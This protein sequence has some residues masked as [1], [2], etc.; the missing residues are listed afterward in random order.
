[1]TD[2]RTT[3]ADLRDAVEDFNRRFP[4][5]AEVTL[6]KDF[7]PDPVR[8]RTRSEAFVLSGHSPVVF[9]EGVVG[10]YL[11]SRVSEVS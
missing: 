8:T 6:R 2:D 10:C 3:P 4:V 9:L 1:M 5:G 7:A 11:V